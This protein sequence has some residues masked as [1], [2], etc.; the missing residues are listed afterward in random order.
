MIEHL[1]QQTLIAYTEGRWNLDG[2]VSALRQYSSQ[3][4]SNEYLD[5]VLDA[6]QNMSGEE[7]KLRNYFCQHFISKR[8]YTSIVERAATS[9]N[10]DTFVSTLPRIVKEQIQTLDDIEEHGSYSTHNSLN[11]LLLFNFGITVELLLKLLCAE[12]RPKNDYL[13]T[14]LLVKLFNDL[15]N[16]EQTMLKRIFKSEILRND[17]RNVR[18]LMKG[19]VHSLS[20]FSLIES[21]ASREEL[22][23][24]WNNLFYMNPEFV[25]K[26][27]T[28]YTPESTDIRVWLKFIDEDIS[29]S[30][31]RY[32]YGK[33]WRFNVEAFDAVQ[34]SLCKAA[35]E[36]NPN[37]NFG[38]PEL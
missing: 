14:H 9:N 37:Y 3:T 6:V 35:M 2:C 27:D 18:V 7:D 21:G 20:L 26:P 36:V 5:K 22:N 25:R 4:G 16:I 13:Y 38:E 32:A 17:R 31:G 33:I 29:P 30:T 34:R 19:N 11:C 24:A 28:V 23:I 8:D 15:G 12:T 10:A 1:V